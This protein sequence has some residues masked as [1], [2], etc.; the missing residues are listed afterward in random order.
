MNRNLFRKR[1]P[2]FVISLERTPERLVR[3]RE[4]N[5][6]ADIEIEVSKAVDGRTLDL[7]TVDPQVL[8]P[9]TVSYRA[10]SV[11][12]ALS[13]RGLWQKCAAGDRPYLVFEDDAA[14]RSDIRTVLPPLVESLDSAWDL[15]ILGYNTDAVAEVVVVD[16]FNLRLAWPQTNPSAA[17]LVKFMDGRWPVAIARAR[18]FFGLCGYLISPSGA[19]ALLRLCFPLESRA[20]NV[21]GL[22]YLMGTFTLDTRM[23]AHLPFIQGFMC[24]PPLVMPDNASSVK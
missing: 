17:Q 11:G 18:T 19:R 3:F 4:W 2:A 16:D 23:N 13:H 1:F 10:G 14:I 21:P 12:S 20:V 8:T 22:S 24:L 5:A 9:G 6:P 15:L 7:A